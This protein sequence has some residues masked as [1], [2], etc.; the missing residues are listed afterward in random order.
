MKIHFFGVRGSLPTPLQSV[1]IQSKIV[2]VVSQIREKDIRTEDDRQRFIAGLPDYLYG[3]VGGNTACIELTLDDG[4][5][6]L[7]DAGTGIRLCGKKYNS[8]K[9]P[10][11]HLFMTH[12]HWDHIQGLPFFDPLYK[13]DSVFHIY[14]ANSDAKKIFSDQMQA[15]HLFP[16]S[17]EAATKN[18]FYHTLQE[19]SPI[20]VGNATVYCKKMFHP[21]ASH[22][23]LFTE[24][25]KR[26]IY[27]TD[28]ELQKNDFERTKENVD[29]FD[30]ADVLVLDSQYTV[31]DAVEKEN[32]GH[33]TFCYAVD[34]AHKFNIKQLYLFHHEPTYDDKKLFS[35]LKSAQWYSDNICNGQ[36]AVHL[37]VEGREIIL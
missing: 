26:F 6:V 21:G 9:N 24:N 1:Q 28:T 32:W 11:F 7:L 8:V 22:A 3:T 37:A 35:I 10:V 4:E 13:K 23:F 30:N 33:S 14:S 15:P 5:T 12:F 34:F 25:G 27:A 19:G 20:V 36:I 29:F 16:V 17:M 18:I 31:E 2:A